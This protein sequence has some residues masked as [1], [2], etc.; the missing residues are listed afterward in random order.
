M[1]NETEN[2]SYLDLRIE[3]NIYILLYIK[4]SYS[5]P[6]FDLPVVVISCGFFTLKFVLVADGPGGMLLPWT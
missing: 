1:E 4:K 2:Y 5:E 6:N 3:R